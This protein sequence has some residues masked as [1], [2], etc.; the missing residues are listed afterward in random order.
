MQF[1]PPTLS[2]DALRKLPVGIDGAPEYSTRR[3]TRVHGQQ[4]M[5]FYHCWWE[6]TLDS[7]ELACRDSDEQTIDRALAV[8]DG[9]ALVAVE[10]DA[11]DGRSRFEFDLGCALITQPIP[12]EN[13][14]DVQWML[15]Q[16][17]GQLLRVRRDGKYSLADARTK[18]DDQSWLPI[19]RE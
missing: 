19:S 8:L 7:R 10:V 11:A 2:I 16:Q 1:G 5:W 4:H 13:E 3:P 9:Q 12:G 14:L 17:S 6:L 15:F 18:E